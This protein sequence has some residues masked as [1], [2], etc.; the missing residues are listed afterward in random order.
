[1]TDAQRF[2]SGRAPVA[3]EDEV[4]GSAERPTPLRLSWY[5]MPA[6][7]PPALVTSVRAIVLRDDAVLVLR[8][9]DGRPYVIPGGRREAGESFEATV[10]R[11]V[12]EEAGWALGLLAP[13]G[14]IHLRNL[15]PK[16]PGNP[17]P[18]PDAF[19][20]VWRAEAAAHRP[21]ARIFDEW[22]ASSAFV[23][24][25]EALA[26]PLRPGERTLLVAA[27]AAP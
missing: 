22:V 7:P 6:E 3:V 12:L 14:R 13:I 20:L 18:Y 21:E 4:W 26:L 17:Y 10:R 24:L 2:L 5:L 16:P 27:L 1:M 25:A 23:P 8:E 11:E 9:P 19:Q 15:G